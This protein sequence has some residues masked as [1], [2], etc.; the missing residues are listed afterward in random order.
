VRR[1]AADVPL[2]WAILERVEPDLSQRGEGSVRLKRE[3]GAVQE[4]G[5]RHARLPD[6]VTFVRPATT[7]SPTQREPN[8]IL[9]F[10]C[11]IS[12]P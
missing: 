8:C 9:A 3:A 2:L 11:A 5:H 12:F 6:A 4:A 7:P 10:S 1:V